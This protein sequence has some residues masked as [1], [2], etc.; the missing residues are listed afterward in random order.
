[1]YFNLTDS[2][3]THAGRDLTVPYRALFSVFSI[4]PHITTAN[5]RELFGWKPGETVGE[6][7][8]RR[9][10]QDKQG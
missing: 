4:D 8:Q 10:S 1:M 5:A 9:A 2:I 3:G 7:A 6:A